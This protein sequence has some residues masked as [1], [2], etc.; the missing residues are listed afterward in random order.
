MD[1][2]TLMDDPKQPIS[3]AI[4][5]FAEQIDLEEQALKRQ[6]DRVAAMNAILARMVALEAGLTPAE[7]QEKAEALS[8]E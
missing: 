1:G 8:D 4:E 2:L 5:A 7:Q 6:Q 3:A